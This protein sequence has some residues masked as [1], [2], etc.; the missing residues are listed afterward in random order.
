M[1]EQKKTIN[2]SRSETWKTAYDM[3]FEFGLEGRK[4]NSCKR[5]H[6]NIL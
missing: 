6:E 1:R 3:I 5:E 4:K 2:Y